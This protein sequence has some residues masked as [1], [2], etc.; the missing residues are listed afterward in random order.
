V[1][2]AIHLGLADEGWTWTQVL[3]RRLFTGRE[4]LTLL[5]RALCDSAWMTPVVPGNTRH[6][7]AQAY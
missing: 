3:S 4:T 7:L 5:R 1:T 6:A 2:P